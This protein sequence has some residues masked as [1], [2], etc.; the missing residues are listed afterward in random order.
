MA[1]ESLGLIG[2]D[3]FHFAVENIA[4]SRS[5][6]V[7][8]LDFREIARAG[9]ALA[10]RSGQESMVLAAGD[11]RVVVSR[12][13]NDKSKAGRFLKQHPCGIMSL[14]FQVK[15]IE[16]AW[17]FLEK[18]GATFLSE[19]LV[20]EKDGGIYRS[21]EIATPLGDLNYRFIERRNYPGFAPG[22][23]NVPHDSRPN[24]FGFTAIDHITSNMRTMAPF[25]LWLEHVLGMERYWD[26]QFH[27]ED[28]RAGRGMGSGLKSIVMWDPES[29]V[30]F[31]N[32]EPLRPYFNA[33]QIAKFVED[34]AGAG[35]QHAALLVPELIPVVDTLR[36]RGVEFLP[37]PKAYYEQLPERFKERN[38]TNITESM[39]EIERLEIQVDGRDDKY[40]LQI[41]MK[42]AANLYN[43]P[44]AGPFF[45]EL[46]QRK[47]HPG[48]GDGNF[49]ALFEAIEREQM[50]AKQTG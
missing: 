49:R 28:V 37:T 6:Y 11:V 24:A 19:I 47:G 10:E 34:N 45:F 50:K 27:T 32:N 8:K 3:S 14:A 30:K 33:S 2:Y 21:F 38:V 18:R 26:V 29:G 48:F 36:Q 15:D 5:F 7:D 31:A 20:D 1:R 12:P 25:V 22:F 44:K 46:I 42:E 23:D 16:Q 13:L 43:E 40:L 39:E 9:S 35:V 41:F 4:R 17:A